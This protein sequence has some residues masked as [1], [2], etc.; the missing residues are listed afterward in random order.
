MLLSNTSNAVSYAGT[1]V[2]AA[3][4]WGANGVPVAWLVSNNPRY[5]KRAY[6]SGTQLM[7]VSH[8]VDADAPRPLEYEA[9][10]CRA[11]L[12]ESRHLSYS[13]LARVQNTSPVMLPVLAHWVSE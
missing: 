5:G 12:R 9:N 1:F 3:G 10:G 6:A 11:M 8:D 4:C 2:V 13:Q 7:M